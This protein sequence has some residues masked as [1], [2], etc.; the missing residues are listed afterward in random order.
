M[1]ARH[2][3]AVSRW[4]VS[5]FRRIASAGFGLIRDTY[6]VRLVIMA[7]SLRR[8]FRLLACFAATGVLL[9]LLIGTLSAVGAYESLKVWRAPFAI[10]VVGAALIGLIVL[11]GCAALIIAGVHA[12]LRLAYDTDRGT[13]GALLT[14]AAILASTVA[15]VEFAPGGLGGLTIIG[16]PLTPVIAFALVALAFW[17]ERAYRRPAYPGFR[18][19]WTDIVEARRSMRRAAHDERAS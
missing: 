5:G 11:E 19:F 4:L 2:T 14:I 6:F 17:F 7:L 13:I 16:V 18:D 12:V 3:R 10:P 1:F 9:C 8:G 15:V